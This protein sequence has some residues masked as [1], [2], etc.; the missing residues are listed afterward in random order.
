M[1]KW[2]AQPTLNTSVAVDEELED[3]PRVHHDHVA[4]PNKIALFMLLRIVLEGEDAVAHQLEGPSSS[5]AKDEPYAPSTCSPGQ[6]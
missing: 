1:E 5:R 3:P 4:V 2:Q 6:V